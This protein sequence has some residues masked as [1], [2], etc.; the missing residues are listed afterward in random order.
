MSFLPQTLSGVK[1]VSICINTPGPVAAARLVQMGANVTKVEPPAGDPLKT[2][3]AAWYGALSAGQTITTLDLKVPGDRAQLDALLASSDLLLASFRPSALRRLHLDW[4][5]LHSRHPKLCF[6]GIVGYPVPQ[7]EKSGHDLTYLAEAG[8]VTP[9]E[10]PSSLFVDLAG[11]ERCVSASLALLL[12][13]TR[14]GEAGCEFVSLFDAARELRAPVQAGLTAKGGILGGGSPL[15][16][17]YHAS[18]GWV[19]VAAL[20]SRF[21]ERLVTELG[22]DKPDFGAI[23]RALQQRRASEWESWAAERDLPIVAVR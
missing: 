21:A 11:A 14:T 23:E 22:L 6:V 2:F 7:E 5:S 1:V 18:E 15:Y 9:P 19:A 17:I 12:R 13:Y 16:N 3:A 8:L 20:E 4:A 10:M